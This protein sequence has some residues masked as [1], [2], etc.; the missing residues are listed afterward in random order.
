MKDRLRD[1]GKNVKLVQLK[2]EDHWLSSSETRL[3]A[4]EAM[5]EFLAKY[6]KQ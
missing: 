4:L 5:G 1:A 6:L 2:G 3:V